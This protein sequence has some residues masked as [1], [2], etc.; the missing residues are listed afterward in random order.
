MDPKEHILNVAE[1]MFAKTG[2]HATSI[3]DIAEAAKI[4]CSMV[5]YY[6]ETKENLYLSIFEKIHQLVE[7]ICIEQDMN[8]EFADSMKLFIKRN[9]DVSSS[10]LCLTKLY[11]SE[12]HI[13]ST[14]L[15]GGMIGNIEKVHFDYFINLTQF[16]A[17]IAS[18]ANKDL[19]YR[20]IF[21]TLKEFIRVTIQGNARI[22]QNYDAKEITE[23]IFK[24]HFT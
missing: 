23:Y 13:S 3:R 1:R 7:C 2:Y 24:S 8:L 21:G 6:F 14:Q 4:N 19:L 11:L 20:A 18:L 15:I 16:N 5:N 17:Q 22:N 9:L 10:E 12:Q